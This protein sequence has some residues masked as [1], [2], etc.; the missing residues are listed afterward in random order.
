MTPFRSFLQHRD[1][2]RNAAVSLGESL[3][4]FGARNPDLYENNPF[5]ERNSF[6]NAFSDGLYLDDFNELEKSGTLTRFITAYSRVEAD[7][8]ILT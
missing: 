4:F 8:V 1:F 3:L 5:V 7:K 6:L 2:L